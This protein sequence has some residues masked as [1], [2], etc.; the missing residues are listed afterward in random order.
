MTEQEILKGYD[1]TVHTFNGDLLPDEVGFYDPKTRT[2]F[3]SDKLNKKERMKVLLHELGHLD[4]TT[5]EYNNAR[6]R[7]ENEANRNMIHHLLKGALSQLENKADFNYMKFMEYYQ[8]TTVT[9]EIM[10][11]EEYKALI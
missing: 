10:I 11:K 7:C 5:A 1:I 9:D 8:L 2:A 6:V 3:I 4:H